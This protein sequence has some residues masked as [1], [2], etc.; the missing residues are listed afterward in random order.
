MSTFDHKCPLCEKAY[1]V[2]QSL[3]RLWDAH[4]GSGHYCEDCDEHFSA[5][6]SWRRHIGT[7]HLSKV[8]DGCF[9]HFRRLNSPDPKARVSQVCLS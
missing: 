2:Y 3:K 8:L 4:H 7:M 1:P 5:Y 9:P 6:S